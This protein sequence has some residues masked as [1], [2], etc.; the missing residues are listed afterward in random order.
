MKTKTIKRSGVFDRDQAK[1]DARQAM[2]ILWSIAISAKSD[3]G[4]T[5]YES[6][7]YEASL[8]VVEREIQSLMISPGAKAM[9]PDEIEGVAKE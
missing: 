8:E 1:R 7:S 9:L 4:V 5:K 3:L 2:D 6:A